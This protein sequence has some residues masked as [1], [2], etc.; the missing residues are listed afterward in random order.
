MTPPRETIF[1]L[2]TVPGRAAIAVVRASGP[3]A[4]VAAERLAGKLPAPRQAKLASFRHPASGELI[5]RGLLLV[6]P[7]GRSETG[8][9]MAEFQLHGGRAVV[10]GLLDALA[11]LPG[12][13]PAEAGEFTRRAFA[14]GRLDLSE[15]E[16]LADL[17]AA[18]TEG[19]RRQA[20]RQM[21]GA[22]SRLTEAWR[23]RLLGA[24]AHLEAVIEFPEEGLP[25][26]LSA[27][28]GRDILSIQ[29]EIHQHLDNDRRG[30]RLREGFQ[31]AILGAPNV[32]K[33][34]LLNAL[35]R[36]DAAIVSETAG[37]TR[38]VIEVTLSLDGYPVTL[39]DT[40]GLRAL[41]AGGGQAAIEAEGIR[42]ARA[43]AEAA[44]L[45]LA[46]F[47]LA[48]SPA[49]DPATLALVDEA[50]LVVGNKLDLVTCATAPNIGGLTPLLVS[51]KR[52]DGM[53][54]LEDVLRAAVE[55]RLG[56]E[57]AVV[58]RLRHRQALEDCAAAL[59]RAAALGLS[60]KTLDLGAEELRQAA[61]ALGRIAGR[62]EVEALLEIVFRDFCIGK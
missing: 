56:G 44:D 34:S 27:T 20:L 46:V 7:E 53:A 21:E 24:L 39:A 49:L 38:D 14:N 61:A 5:D 1:A 45:K 6:F 12:L 30:E 29:T 17:I 13:R 54:A 16:G 32:G 8:E 22:L 19:Q 41:D 33:S 18:E 9:N 26:G 48:A 43:R 52:G 3:E 37:T 51:A 10:A 2:S 40:A 36:R 58:T 28:V 23:A 42:R 50:T 15:V 35:A 55:A 59:A 31:V 62:V 47:D 11:T 60:D 25:E 4:L 57:P